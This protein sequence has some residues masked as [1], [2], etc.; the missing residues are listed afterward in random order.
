MWSRNSDEKQLMHSKSD[1]IEITIGNNANRNYNQKLEFMI[2]NNTDEIVHE[3]FYSLLHKYQKGLEE[4]MKG[5]DFV[6]ILMDCM[7]SIIR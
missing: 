1:N 3:R 4:S 2:G 7:T 6:V 5:S